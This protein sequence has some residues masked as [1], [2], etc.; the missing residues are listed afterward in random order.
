MK[1]PALVV[2]C[3]LASASTVW[4]Q[5]YDHVVVTARSHAS[6]YAPLSG[7]VESALGLS[8]TVVAVEDVV[9]GF[10]GRDGPEKIRS[11]IRYAYTNWGTSSVLLGG[12]VDIIPCRYAYAYRNQVEYIPCDL[13]YS[14][15]DRDWDADGNSVFGEVTDSVDLYPDVHV[16]RVPSSSAG[17]AAGYVGKFL[18]YVSDST[19]PYLDRVFLNGF[20]LYHTPVIYGEYACEYYDTTLVPENMRPCTKVYDSHTGNHRTATLQKL[21]EGMHFWVHADH[22]GWWVMGTGWE[23]HRTY[24]DTSDLSGLSNGTAYSIL[25]SVGCSTGAFDED[26]C[27]SEV[28]I[29]ALNGGIAAL[30]NS[31]AGLLQGPKWHHMASFL[32]VEENLFAFF[33]DVHSSSL[34]ELARVQSVIAPLA[35]TSACYRW[36]HY[37]Y[38]LLGEPLMPVWLPEPAGVE[39]EQGGRTTAGR[40][41]PSIVREVLLWS[42]ATRSLRN[43][44]DIALHS[45]DGRKVMELRPGE[46]DVRGLA[47]GVYFVR[48][49][50]PGIPGSEGSSVRIVIAR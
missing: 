17:D 29:E 38:H 20:D 31:R 33:D 25:L 45:I 28:F 43:V 27:C 23:N 42:A 13:Y 5:L 46:N 34:S 24:I 48:G 36:C 39:D 11:F 16:G 30:T 7:W 14:D 32:Q 49:E 47:P 22:C 19:A 12:D 10:P 9:A 21:N 8:D 50:G 6:A 18:T 37:Q 26:D 41:I 3:T 2:L 1:S 40:R 35:D 15:L 44:G 4:A